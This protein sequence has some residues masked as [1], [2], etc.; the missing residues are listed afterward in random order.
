MKADPL[1]ITRIEDAAGNVVE[2]RVPSY[3][4]IMSSQTAYLITTL[5]EGV[6]QH[7]T[8]RKAKVLNRPVAGKTGT[9]NDQHDAWFVGFTPDL[10]ATV[11]IGYDDHRPLGPKGTGGAV[12]APIWLDFMQ[13]ALAGMPVKEFAMP[14]GIACVNIDPASGLRARENNLNAY[15][16]CFKRGTEPREFAPVWRVDPDSGS[17]TMVVQPAE[18]D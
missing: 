7:G 14:E 5:L 13:K 9:T 15:L 11:W 12:A 6:V 18:A 3:N 1:F 8:G 10:L 16:E 2:Q 17:E 4:E